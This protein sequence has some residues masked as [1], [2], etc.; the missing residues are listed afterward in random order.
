MRIWR[1]P[2]LLLIPIMVPAAVLAP[3]FV[4]ATPSPQPSA[5]TR[6]L[7]TDLIPRLLRWKAGPEQ[8]F[9]FRD[10]ARSRG[11]EFIC[12]VRDYS[13]LDQG[14]RGG[15]PIDRYATSFGLYIPENHTAFVVTRGREAHAVLVRN[16]DIALGGVTADRRCVPAAQAILTHSGRNAPAG[17]SILLGDGPLPG[18][19]PGP[20]A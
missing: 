11:Y 4:N 1:H 10:L 3:R 16:A 6:F 14:L 15:P 17:T 2:V 12:L 13:M 20:P 8:G 5:E 7:E 9:A 19:I 18:A